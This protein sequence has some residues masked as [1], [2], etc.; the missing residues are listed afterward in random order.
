MV[1][2]KSFTDLLLN[3]CLTDHPFFAVNQ[4]LCMIAIVFDQRGGWVGVAGWVMCGSV[5]GLDRV[6]R[7]PKSLPITR[8]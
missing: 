7:S 2:D 8:K 6:R 5:T 4:I 3:H 1:W